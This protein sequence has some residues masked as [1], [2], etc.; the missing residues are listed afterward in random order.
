ML[1]LWKSIERILNDGELVKKKTEQSSQSLVLTG[2][3][4]HMMHD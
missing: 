3:M 4:D 1:F 2:E